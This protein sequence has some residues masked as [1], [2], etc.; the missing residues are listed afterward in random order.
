MKELQQSAPSG[1]SR[2]GDCERLPYRLF[3]IRAVDGKR[4]TY[5]RLTA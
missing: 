5:A 4:L 1:A 2:R 3:F